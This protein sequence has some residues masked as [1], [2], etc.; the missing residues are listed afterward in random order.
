M[1]ARILISLV[2]AGSALVSFGAASAAPGRV[3]TLDEII[4]AASRGPRARAA[5]ARTREARGARTEARGSRFPRLDVRGVLGPS[6]EI[7]CLDVACTETDPVDPSLDL[8]GLFGRIELTLIQPLYTFGK[9][10]AAAGASEHAIRAARSLEDA[11][12][13]EVALEAARAYYGLKL[14]RETRYM[15]EDGSER[16]AKALE[17]VNREIAAGSAGVTLQDRYRLET[18]GAEIDLRLADARAGEARALAAI[19]ILTGDRTATIDEEPLAA[20]SY[21][22]GTEAALVDRA[23]VQ[24]PEVRAAEAARRAASE[25]ARLESARFWP[26][27]LLLGSLN[28]A[29]ASGVDNAPSAF[30]NDPYNTTTA[31]AGLGLRWNFDPFAQRGRI[32]QA[33]ARTRR[34]GHLAAAAE[35]RARFQAHQAYAEIERTRRRLEA[36]RKGERSARAWLASALQ[37]EAVG[38]VEPKDLADAYLAFFTA[39]GRSLEAIN[40][41]NLAVYQARRS[42]GE[43]AARD[44]V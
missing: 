40:E 36:A 39:R 32:E 27:L 25:L 3:W 28:L 20:I 33:R 2:V 4:A 35:R 1:L 19:R 9:L 23:K 13:A 7:E 42:A 38:A 11:T 22:S 31:A 21:Q 41:W 16:L 17:R 14:A 44:G 24:S 8:A 34:A 5:A 37:A 12:A 10:G 29:A 43:F 30:A 18:L 26:D 6:P 15:L